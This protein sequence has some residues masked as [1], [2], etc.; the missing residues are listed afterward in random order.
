[1]N[2]WINSQG[3]IVFIWVYTLLFSIII[4][5]RSCTRPDW[6]KSHIFSDF[7]TG[8]AF[9]IVFVTLKQMKKPKLGITL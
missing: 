1:M 5:R 7:K 9:F 6:S 2:E 3:S 4:E 8:K